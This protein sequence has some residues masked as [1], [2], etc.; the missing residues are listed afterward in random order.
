MRFGK[1]SFSSFGLVALALAASTAIGQ[2]ISADYQPIR[3]GSRPTVTLAS[4]YAT[5]ADY[6]SGCGCQAAAPNCGSG[7]CCQ[8]LNSCCSCAPQ[9]GNSGCQN[10][11]QSGCDCCCDRGEAWEQ[12]TGFFAEFLYLRAFGVDMAHGFQQNGVGGLGTTPDGRVGTVSPEFEPAYSIGFNLVLDPCEPCSS[13]SGTFTNFTSRSTDTLLAPGGV[14]GTLESLVLHPNTVT[15]ASTFSELDAYYA[16]DYQTYDIDFHHLLW[17]CD[18]HAI[19]LLIGARYAHLK[20]LF[21]QDGAFAGATGSE[22]TNTNILFDGGGLRVGLDGNWRFGNRGFSFYG[23]GALNM[24]FGEFRSNYTQLNTTT[25]VVEANSFMDDD[26][27]MPVLEYELGLSWTS[28]N[29]RLMLS[30]GYYTAFW[31]NAVT[32]PDYIQS[33]Q[34]GNFVEHGG[35]DTITFTGFTSKVEYRF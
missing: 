34:N 11:C 12:R 27:V 6:D 4:G 19:N 14:G 28:C 1:T 32:T 2:E 10:G 21:E 35:S 23:K 24:L 16:I 25:T 15:A 5:P 29:G 31:F 8:Q 18:D 7:P 9:C 20:Q 3:D 13:I 30:T 17:G 33:V 22:Q 26:R